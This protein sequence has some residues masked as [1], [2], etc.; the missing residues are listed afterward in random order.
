MTTELDRE[1]PPTMKIFGREPAAFIGLISG[2]LALL[3]SLN[4]FG[5]T[6]ENVGLIMG[7][8]TAAFGIYTAYVT[9][10]T[11]LG[12]IVA[13]VNAIFAL[14]AGYGFE[15]SPD[16]TA[17]AI[18]I[19]TVMVGFFQRTQTSPLAKGSFN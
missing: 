12:V 2:A 7:A 4:L 19:V 13:F 1:D 8:V 3:L 15:L 9:K 14:V 5:L 18:A 17:A 6:N 11:M 16:T 10:D